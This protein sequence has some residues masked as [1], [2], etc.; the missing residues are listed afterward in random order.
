MRSIGA[1]FG[2]VAF[3]IAVAISL[4]MWST[5]NFEVA[6]YGLPAQKQAQHIAGYDD[7]G[8]PAMNSFQLVA[9][10]KDG[11]LQ[12]M[13]VDS[14]NAQGAMAKQFGLLPKDAIVAAGP[15]NFR[16]FGYDE[17]MARALIL[18][19]FQKK[20]VGR[21]TVLRNGKTVQLPIPL[22]PAAAVNAASGG[23][24]SADGGQTAE[25]RKA[26]EEEKATPKELAPLKGILR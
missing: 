18:T 6:K 3:L 24:S 9:E 15:I 19:E 12:Y 13:I 4:W 7:Q 2:L 23:A 21:L 5:Y 25:N 26:V 20:D 1:G 22:D 8:R 14:I 17:E 16:D 11:K 10:E